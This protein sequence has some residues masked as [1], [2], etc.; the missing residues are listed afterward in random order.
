MPRCVPFYQMLLHGYVDYAGQSINL[1]YDSN[2]YLLRSLEFGAIPYF[3]LITEKNTNIT[4]TA[5]ETVYFSVNDGAHLENIAKIYERVAPYYTAIQGQKLIS[6]ETLA[7][8][9][10]CTTYENGSKMY[11]NYSNS[12]ITLDGVTVKAKDFTFAQ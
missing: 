12:D 8:D 4:S 6:H 5:Y 1:S 2:E 3:T 10:F 7:T 9:L 11:V